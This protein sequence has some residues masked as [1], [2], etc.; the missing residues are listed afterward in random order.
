MLWLVLI[1]ILSL[2]ELGNEGA[3]RVDQLDKVVHFLFHYVLSFLLLFHLKYDDVLFQVKRIFYFVFF[4]SLI[5][6]VLIEGLQA[7]LTL[8]R[9][10][11]LWDVLA[12]TLGC[13]T[14]LLSFRYFLRLKRQ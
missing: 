10:S 2:I 7:V 6:G 11:D 3:P 13:L 9:E 4:F 5:Y 8:R 12:N 14:C 1:T